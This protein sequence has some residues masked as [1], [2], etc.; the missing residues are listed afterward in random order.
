MDVEAAF[1]QRFP[2]PAAHSP[3]QCELCVFRGRPPK[4]AAVHQA[5]LRSDCAVVAER[6]L[7]YEIAVGEF[8]EGDSLY[9]GSFLLAQGYGLFSNFCDF[10]Y[11][12]VRGHSSKVLP[13]ISRRGREKRLILIDKSG[14]PRLFQWLIL[15]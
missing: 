12:L 4:F 2:L 7:D 13:A 14:H 10:G 9:P 11:F 15:L 5:G 3:H 6:D 1:I 8:E